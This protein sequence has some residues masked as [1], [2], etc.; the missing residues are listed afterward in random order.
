MTLSGRWPDIVPHMFC[1]KAI[2]LLHAHLV[3]QTFKLAKA[4]VGQEIFRH[5]TTLSLSFDLGLIRYVR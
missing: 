4:S 3:M 1:G 2:I 5:V